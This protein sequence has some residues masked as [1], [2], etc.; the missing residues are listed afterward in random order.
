MPVAN[1]ENLRKNIY[2]Y[3]W[4]HRLLLARQA[5]ENS[6]AARKD[7]SYRYYRSVNLLELSKVQF[8]RFRQGDD[9]HMACRFMQVRTRIRFDVSFEFLPLMYLL[10]LGSFQANERVFAFSSGD[11][12]DLL[13]AP[14]VARERLADGGVPVTVFSLVQTLHRLFV[15]R[16]AGE[17]REALWNS[18]EVPNA[19]RS[20][21]ADNILLLRDQREHGVLVHD[22]GEGCVDDGNHFLLQSLMWDLASKRK[23]S[24][25]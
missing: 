16:D 18:S 22:D 2:V 14:E 4:F 12:I 11:G 21:E 7:D 24:V 1:M 23:R 17:L 25:Q 6:M 20:L 8:L 13:L 19:I 3:K 5:R 10:S 9:R 15:H